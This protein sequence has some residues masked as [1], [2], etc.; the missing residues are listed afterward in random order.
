MIASDESVERDY[1]Q[2]AA[3]AY[4]AIHRCALCVRKSCARQAVFE[5]CQFLVRLGAKLCERGRIALS[6]DRS[7]QFAIDR[8]QSV[9]ERASRV[10]AKTPGFG[11]AAVELA[12]HRIEDPVKRSVGS[13]TQAS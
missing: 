11:S 8:A 6:P 13:A 7:Q 10:S 12:D 2:P 4:Q 5:R 3:L 9:D 1:R